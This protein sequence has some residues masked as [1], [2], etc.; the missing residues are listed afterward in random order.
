MIN[1]GIN[2]TGNAK[3]NVKGNL[4]VGNNSV[5]DNHLKWLQ[6][7]KWIENNQKNINNYEE[8]LEQIKILKEHT[9]EINESQK[10]SIFKK[11][12]NLIVPFTTSINFI[13][14][15]QSVFDEN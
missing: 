4:T 15:I 12:T 11:I 7:D 6:V 14:I 2:V 13:K 8:L 10:D 3:I 9:Y 5:E 1:N